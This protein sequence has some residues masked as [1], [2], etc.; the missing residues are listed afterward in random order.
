MGSIR[1]DAWANAHH[2]AVEQDKPALE[3]G[4]YLHPDLYRESEQKRIGSA[5]SP[6]LIT[7][8]LSR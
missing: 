1:Q 5:H 6:E 8:A 2:M 4:H 3:Q 7:P